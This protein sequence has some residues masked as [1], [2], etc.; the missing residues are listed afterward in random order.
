MLTLDVIEHAQ[1]HWAWLIVFFPEKNGTLCLCVDYLDQNAVTIS[2]LYLIP[3]ME[4][5]IDALGDD[6]M[7]RLFN[8]G[9]GSRY[10]QFEITEQDRDKNGI[11]LSSRIIP[12]HTNAFCDEN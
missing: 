4:E 1:A 6:K 7:I 9:W 2:G 11:H 12:L 3:G 8:F 5:C 10:W